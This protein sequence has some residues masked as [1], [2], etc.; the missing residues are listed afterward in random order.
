ML[1]FGIVGGSEAGTRLMNSIQSP[2]SLCER[3]K[4]PLYWMELIYLQGETFHGFILDR[5]RKL[6]DLCISL[7]V[8]NPHRSQILRYKWVTA[9]STQLIKT[10]IFCKK[11]TR[12]F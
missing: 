11:A 8:A 1:W 6:A 10:K 4:H 12:H 3:G 7:H 2:W 9:A 5:I